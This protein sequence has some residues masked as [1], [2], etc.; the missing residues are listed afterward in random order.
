MRTANEPDLKGARNAERRLQNAIVDAIHVCL[1][2]TR[3][4]YVVLEGF[5]VDVATFLR[6]GDRLSLRLLELKAYVGSRPGGVG[7]GD[8]R[9]RGAQI[10][11]LWDSDREEPRSTA[12]L[13]TIDGSVRWILADGLKRAG[14]PRYA[15]FNCAEAQRAAMGGVQPGKQNNLRVNAFHDTLLTWPELLDHLRQFLLS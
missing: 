1:G 13:L 14:L 6:A 9:G 5:G 8:Q 10:D 12:Q 7:F 4:D 11:L 3:V 2:E 15:F